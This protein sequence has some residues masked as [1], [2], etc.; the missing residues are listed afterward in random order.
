M[1]QGQ[2]GRRQLSAGGQA[3]SQFRIQQWMYDAYLRQ[4]VNFF[5]TTENRLNRLGNGLK[6]PSDQRFEEAKVETSQD[7]GGNGGTMH[8]RHDALRCE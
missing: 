2:L 3:F 8:S 6:C 4:A 1:D 5:P 7:L